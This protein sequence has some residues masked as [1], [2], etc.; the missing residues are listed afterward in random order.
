MV[1]DRWRDV[2]AGIAAGCKTIFIDCGYDERRPQSYDFQVSSLQEAVLIILRE[3]W[4]E[5]N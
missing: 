2:D 1:G 4:H 5:Q 3:R